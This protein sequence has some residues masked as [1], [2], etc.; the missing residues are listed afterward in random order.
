MQAA[1]SWPEAERIALR[2]AKRFHIVGHDAEDVQQEARV[3]AHRALS[4][5]D[6]R[7]VGNCRYV[8][9][10]VRG[11]LA[12]LLRKETALKRQPTDGRNR[13]L[14]FAPYTDDDIATESTTV[15]EAHDVR[16]L[17]ET[18]PGN[19][20]GGV[21]DA[22]REAMESGTTDATDRLKALQAM[23]GDVI[24]K[25]EEEAVHEPPALM[26][27]EKVKPCH[28][29]GDMPQGYDPTGKSGCDLCMQKFTCLPQT[30][31]RGL[32]DATM[33]SDL[34]V[35]AVWARRRH[36]KDMT[37]RMEKRHRLGQ[38]GAPV[39]EE[40]AP[41][42]PA[43]LP[44][45]V[46]AQPS[47]DRRKKLYGGRSWKMPASKPASPE[48]MQRALER[49]RLGQDFTLAPGMSVERILATGRQVTV[50]IT[51]RGFQ[52]AGYLYGSL[53][54]AVMSVEHRS[55]SGNDFFS[56]KHRAVTIRDS[57]GEVMVR[58]QR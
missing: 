56:L 6:G 7:E 17:L 46:Q 3:A 33:Q 1:L 57:D 27:F 32:T 48:K 58:S 40:L 16:R 8:R 36:A 4:R 37:L 35:A 13:V 52:A 41:T 39:P 55:C 9:E 2:E 53:S 20:L 15:E 22:L 38:Q 25:V 47:T 10:S 30:V 31:K 19:K 49:V 11:A 14:Y 54:A 23:L 5:L 18:V 21:I 43:L 28:P 44:A 50:E 26:Y 12:K 29:E 51:D 34:E 24:A 42:W 45:G